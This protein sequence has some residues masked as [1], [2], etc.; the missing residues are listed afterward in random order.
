MVRFGASRTSI[1]LR[2][3]DG[4]NL[5][6]PAADVRILDDLKAG[7]RRSARRPVATDF[8]MYCPIAVFA[9]GRTDEAHRLR[10]VFA[11]EVERS[12]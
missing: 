12:A 3:T 11:R 1:T 9:A 2:L 10:F 6:L 5:E 7:A 8:T 4:G